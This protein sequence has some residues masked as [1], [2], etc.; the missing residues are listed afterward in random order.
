[1]AARCRQFI[2][3]FYLNILKKYLLKAPT[4]GFSKK[5]KV[6][7]L[8]QVKSMAYQKHSDKLIVVKNKA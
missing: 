3:V 4:E 1:M 7:F 8:I 6:G 5:I 2:I